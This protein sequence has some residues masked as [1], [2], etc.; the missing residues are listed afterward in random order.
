M[1]LPVPD[2]VVF[3]GVG[4]IRAIDHPPVHAEDE[5]EPAAVVPSDVNSAEP[6]DEGDAAP[7]PGLQQG[8]RIVTADEAN[9]AA[10]KS[11]EGRRS[12]VFVAHQLL[13]SHNTLTNG[14]Q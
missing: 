2:V 9:A 1:A 8:V 10:L 6:I 7:R 14:S 3:L 13:D 4:R 11:A 12:G 5:P